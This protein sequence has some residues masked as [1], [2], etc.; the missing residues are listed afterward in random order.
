M[1]KGGS[2]QPV[3]PLAEAQAQ[4]K[5]LQEQ[6]RIDEQQRLAEIERENQQREQ[7]IADFNANL[8]T[9]VSGALGRAQTLFD[10]RGLNYSDYEDALRNELQQVRTTVPYL[11]ENPSSYFGD[12]VIENFLQRQTANRQRELT[13][14]FD[15]FAGDNFARNLFS[16]T[17]DDAVIN[18]ILQEQYDPALQTLTNALNRGLINQQGF[19]AGLASLSGQR[20]AA[21]SRL[22]DLGSGVLSGYRGQLRDIAEEG[23]T[24]I[25]GYNLGDTFDPSGY[26]TRIGDLST[27]LTGRLEGD[28]RGTLGGEQLFNVND[29]IQRSG[30]AQGVTNSTGT[31]ADVFA[32]RSSK[33]NKRDQ[34]ERGLGSTG[35]F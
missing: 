34:Q 7:D 32:E 26:Q 29:I 20:T 6:A 23:R 15:Q 31:L 21:Q 9:A 11:N 25:A 8:D 28:I 16:D 2:V 33:R 13:N 5:I 17:S 10:E 35:V 30:T 12:P 14:Q 22:Q 24:K 3:D 27:D 19:D 1:A 18:S 4:I